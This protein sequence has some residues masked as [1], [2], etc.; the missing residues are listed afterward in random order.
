MRKLLALALFVLTLTARAQIVDLGF[1]KEIDEFT[2]V[3]ICT[4][5]VL[6]EGE[7]HLPQIGIMRSES[8]LS[9]QLWREGL[10][11]DQVGH[12][13]Y[14]TGGDTIMLKVSGKVH[15]FRIVDSEALFDTED[16][17]AMLMESAVVFRIPG[18][19]LKK[20]LDS[21]Q[22]VRYRLTNNAGQPH[23]DGTLQ[24]GMFKPLNAFQKKCK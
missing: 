1:E 11:M 12:S 4:Q 18:P 7:Q 16:S 19:L 5:Q 17:L 23:Y 10:E 14:S 22:D 21:K 6:D 20:I 24:V 13:I 2:E 8:G 3:V 15:T 9:M